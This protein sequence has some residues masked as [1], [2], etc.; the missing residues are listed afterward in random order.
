MVKLLPLC[1]YVEAT[2]ESAAENIC[3]SSARTIKRHVENSWAETLSRE[4]IN[5]LKN[6]LPFQSLFNTIASR[7][8]S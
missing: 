7:I 5:N 2:L 8:F 4:S 1:K 3:L 6:H